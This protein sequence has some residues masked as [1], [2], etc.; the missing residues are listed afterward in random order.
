M[1]DPA[2]IDRRAVENLILTLKSYS[3]GAVDAH[4]AADTL[5]HLFAAYEAEKARAD[6]AT[7][8]RDEAREYAKQ[9]RLREKAAEDKRV[10]D[11][12]K[13]R[14]ALAKAVSENKSLKEPLK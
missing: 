3:A 11:V 10:H 7:R 6:E 9:A 14:A 4:D 8:K 5:T 1:T 12:D 13:A 2:P